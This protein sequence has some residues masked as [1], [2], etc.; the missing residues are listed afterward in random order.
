MAAS[1]GY[2]GGLRD[3]LEDERKR[4]ESLGGNWNDVIRMQNRA[5]PESYNAETY[6]N[7][8]GQEGATGG[9]FTGQDLNQFQSLLNRLTSSK[10][11]QQ[12]QKSK[13]GR[14]DIYAGGLASMMRNF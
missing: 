9:T 14:K 4:F 13:E 12:K 1:L 11:T 5:E 10:M 8:R 2:S 6:I 7:D 3:N